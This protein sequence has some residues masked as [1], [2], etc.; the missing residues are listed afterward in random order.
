MNRSTQN[1]HGWRR[2]YCMRCG[3]SID[4]LVDCGKRFCPDCSRR[5]ARRIQNRL[6]ALFNKIQIQPRAGLKM[7]TLSTPNCTRLQPGIRHLVSSFRRLRQRSL[8]KHYVIGGAFV[9]EVKGRPGNWHPHIHAII[10]SY[11]LPWRRLWHAWTLVSGGTAVWISN[12]A[13]SQA[14]RYVTKYV[15]KCDMPPALQDEVSDALRHFRLFTRFGAWH[16]IVLPKLKFDCPCQE[17]GHSDWM[18][19]IELNQRIKHPEYRP[20]QVVQG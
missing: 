17:C 6:Q 20:S 9:I 16:N 8:W 5:R 3:H 18:V 15:T 19:D 4:V 1:S 14:K 10:Y 12:I 2:L 13:P 11:Y 7:I